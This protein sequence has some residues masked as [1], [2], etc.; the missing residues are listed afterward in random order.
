MQLT[1]LKH[2]LYKANA[3]LEK[4]YR[5]KDSKGCYFIN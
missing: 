1:S 4:L 2:K 5:R 3:F